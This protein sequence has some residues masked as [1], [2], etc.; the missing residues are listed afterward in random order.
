MRQRSGLLLKRL[1][2]WLLQRRLNGRLLQR[3]LPAW[4]L[5]VVQHKMYLVA[6]R[7]RLPPL[8]MVAQVERLLQHQVHLEMEIMF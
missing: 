8:V 2:A 1:P 5:Q 7:V 6:Q 3:K 4:L